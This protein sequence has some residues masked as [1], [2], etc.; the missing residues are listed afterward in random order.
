MPQT[1]TIATIATLRIFLKTHTGVGWLHKDFSF[2]FFL[3]M[4]FKKIISSWF[5]MQVLKFLKAEMW[6]DKVQKNVLVCL[7]N[8]NI[9][10]IRLMFARKWNYLWSLKKWVWWCSS[11]LVAG[12]DSGYSFFLPASQHSCPHV[13]PRLLPWPEWC[14]TLWLA[15]KAGLWHKNTVTESK[16][17]EN[18]KHIDKRGFTS[19]S[20]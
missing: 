10:T 13:T 7:Q 18:T 1:S 3:K 8:L 9:L 11:P 2:Q 15:H 6:D 14:H 12:T 4:E 5:Q 19:Y 16:Q 17:K 20:V